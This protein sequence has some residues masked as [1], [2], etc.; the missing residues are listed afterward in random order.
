MPFEGGG[1]CW[2]EQ[3]PRQ[4]SEVR[5]RAG[6]LDEMLHSSL[7]LKKIKELIMESTIFLKCHQCGARNRINIHVADLRIKE[8][9]SV[10][11]G[12]CH[13]KMR[14]N[15]ITSLSLS[16]EKQ[17]D[18]NNGHDRE[19]SYKELDPQKDASDKSL[20]ISVALTLVIY[21]G[22]YYLLKQTFS[23]EDIIDDIVTLGFLGL[24][25]VPFI[26]VIVESSIGKTI[27]KVTSI[28]EKSKLYDQL[29]TEFDS[30]E[31]DKV[32][33]LKE[34][35]EWQ[36]TMKKE[37]NKLQQKKRNFE[38][39]ITEQ[40]N[41]LEKIASEKS[42]GFPWLATAYSEYFELLDQKTARQ[43]ET[44]KRPALK[45]ADEVR[46]I[47]K[48]KREAEE[49]ARILK[50]QIGYYEKLFPWL[51]DFKDENIEDILIEVSDDNEDDSEPAKRWLSEAEYKNLPNSEKYQLA[52]ERYWKNRKSKWQIGRDYERYVGYLYEAEGY[53]V[54]YQGAIEGFNDLGRD[55]IA[56]KDKSIEI[57]QCKYWSKE[58]TIH[59]KHIF[60]LYGT[61]IAYELDNPRKNVVG[62]LVTS[63]TLSDRARQFAKKLNIK[64]REMFCLVN[65]PCI[66]CNISRRDG[67][68]IYHLP[69]D[70]QY[71]KVCIELNR[72][73][74]YVSSV[75]EAEALGFRRAH[76]WHSNE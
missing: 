70:Q 55:I 33:L 28:I 76:R 7:G 50:Y 58:K 71:D 47:S 45:A 57:V 6:M 53:K 39:Y 36:S 51:I 73:E 32:A 63:T 37:Q 19:S 31:K 68:K 62:V 40:H 26:Y 44:K 1:R 15:P 23:L 66:K 41:A 11:C 24:F 38:G 56:Y 35:A 10:I 5:E 34:K 75:S 25:L 27:N 8:G 22:G 3:K 18:R 13:T 2:G 30:I 69:F 14:Y 16:E 46:R 54:V 74:R 64:V 43:L 60:Q 20:K 49:K 61:M 42:K 9:K 59:E 52:L 21:V 12:E 72:G 17:G 29:R 67:T 4:L 65:Y 48:L